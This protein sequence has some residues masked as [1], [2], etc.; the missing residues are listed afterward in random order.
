MT[1]LGLAI[2]IGSILALVFLVRRSMPLK[3]LK[4]TRP[5]MI[6]TL[7][8]RALSFGLGVVSYVANRLLS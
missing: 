1:R 6:V 5:L 2:V 7:V 8:M 4:K 3:L